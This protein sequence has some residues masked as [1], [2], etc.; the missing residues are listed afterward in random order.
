MERNP[1]LERE[2]YFAGY[3]ESIDKLKNRPDIVSFDKLCYE[4]FQNNE[5]GRKFMEFVEQR[6]LIPSLA[7]LQMTNYQQAVI[8]GEGFKDAFRTIKQAVMSH[9]QRIKAETDKNDR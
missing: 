8:W 6:Y 4:I 2:N 9:T 1:Y 7:N 3:Q 5:S